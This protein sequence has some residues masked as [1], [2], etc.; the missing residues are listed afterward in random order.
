MYA[1]LGSFALSLEELISIN[2]FSIEANFSNILALSSLA[3]Y[4]VKSPF[5]RII[6]EPN[7]NK[8]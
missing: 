2:S 4:E 8:S 7:F 6:S 5:V 3:K 1:T